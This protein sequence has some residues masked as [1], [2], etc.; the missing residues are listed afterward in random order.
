MTTLDDIKRK[1]QGILA[2][3]KQGSGATEEEAQAALEFARRL[4]L[5]HQIDETD[6][7]SGPARSVHEIA[8]DLEY[9][10]A[11]GY[12]EGAKMSTWA[13]ILAAAVKNLIGTVDAY[14]GRRNT[15]S[16]NLDNS[17]KFDELGL[18]E[19]GCQMIFY[20]PAEDARDAVL[21]FNEYCILVAAM[22][23]L[24]YGGALRGEGRSY[25]EGFVMALYK[26]VDQIKKDEQRQI[27][28]CQSSALILVSSLSLM[29]AKLEKAQQWLKEEQ[30]V[31]LKKGTGGSGQHHSHAFDDGQVDGNNTN[32]QH[33][34]I[35]KLR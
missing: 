2:K 22:A 21:L 1:L 33:Q 8:A 24:K 28:S 20:G 34:R 10:Q 12:S 26:K 7:Q 32:F 14:S 11:I 23:R 17:V 19:K 18:P 16:R 31:R 4:M 5:K 27:Q 29:Q 30:G 13:K 15:V 3:A 9:G 25:A 35:K 6:L